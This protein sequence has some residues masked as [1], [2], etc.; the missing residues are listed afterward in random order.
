MWQL[1]GDQV[2]E[3]IMTDIELVTVTVCDSLLWSTG[4]QQIPPS[5]PP[6]KQQGEANKEK[7]FYIYYI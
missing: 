5:L 4:C 2:S 3:L 7:G 6:Q 1:Q